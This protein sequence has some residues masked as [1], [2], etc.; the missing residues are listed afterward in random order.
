MVTRIRAGFQRA[1]TRCRFFVPVT[2]LKLTGGFPE[3]ILAD[4][5]SDTVDLPTPNSFAIS[6]AFSPF[7]YLSKIRN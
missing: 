3:F 4:L 1:S 7:S 6:S 2:P 5:M